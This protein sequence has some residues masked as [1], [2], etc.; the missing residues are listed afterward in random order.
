MT[1]PA[2]VQ[3]ICQYVHC[4]T[5]TTIAAPSFNC[6]KEIFVEMILWEAKERFVKMILWQ[7]NLILCLKFAC[8]SQKA[9]SELK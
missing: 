1:F 9:M 2:P 3:M 8:Q 4:S 7:T 6:K 5:L